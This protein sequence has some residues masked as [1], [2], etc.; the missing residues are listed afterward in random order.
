MVPP[1]VKLLWS[2]RKVEVEVDPFVSTALLA[3]KL[4][5]VTLVSA[6]AV[7]FS[8]NAPEMVVFPPPSNVMA[9][10]LEVATPE[11]QVQEPPGTVTVSP[12]CAELIAFCT[13]ACEQEAALIVAA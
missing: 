7:G 10:L 13:S 6:D 12:L 9:T 2:T 4:K 3:V 5:P 1:P 8:V 11:A